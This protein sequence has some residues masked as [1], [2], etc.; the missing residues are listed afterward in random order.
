ML[1]LLGIMKEALNTL[2]NPTLAMQQVCA[3]PAQPSRRSY[4]QWHFSGCSLALGL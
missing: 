1:R 3:G 4:R 2:G